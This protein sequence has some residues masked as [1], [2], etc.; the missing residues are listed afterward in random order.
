MY[1]KLTLLI[2]VVL[3][4]GLL[5]SCTPA[6]PETVVETR[7]VVV[8]EEREVTRTI[9]E[10]I[11]VTRVVVEEGE[12]AEPAPAAE[13]SYERSETLYTSG[14]Q[15]GP[16]TNWNPM[17]TWNYATGTI[18]LL[19]EPL[20][21]Y[22][23]L[24]DE[25]IPWLAESGEW[26]DDNVYEL[27]LREGIEWTDGEPFNAEDVVFTFELGQRFPTV[28]YSPMWDWLESAEQTDDYTVVFTFSDPLYQ[29][30]GNFLYSRVMVPEHLWA[31]KTEEEV[32][33]GANENPV[34]TGPYLYE[35]H[36]QDRMVWVKND[37]WWAIDALDM[38]VA[39]RRIVDIVNGSNNVAL[40]MVL[41]GQLD[42][43]NNFLPGVAT[44]VQGGYGV[45]TYYP[46][47]PYM[48]SANTAWLVMN[49][50]QTPTDDPA[51][52]RAMAH[53]INVDEIVEVVYGNIVQASN[54]TGLLPI[55]DEY[56]DQAV[57]DEM[58]FSYDPDQARAILA[59]A[60]YEDTDGDGFVE[61]PDGEPIELTIIVPFGW[62]DWMEAARVIASSAQAAGINVEPEFPDFGGYSDQR[63][64]GNYDLLVSNDAQ[65]S[66]TV[67]TYYDWIFQEPVQETMTNGNYQRYDNQE[68]FDLVVELD[69]TPVDDTEAM[70]E[71][72]S[73]LQEIQL[74][75]MPIVP[76][77]YN[78]LWAQYNNTYWTNWPSAEEG[79]N[80]YL[81]ATWR[82]YWNMTGILMLTEIEP[83]EAATE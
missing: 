32:V 83:A 63:N 50:E 37:N 38:D 27:T 70:Q 33:S 45:Q 31:D 59:E 79:S 67:W 78:G 13:T 51:F 44:L 19:Y 71:I 69:K 18:G 17:V 14:T 47:P 15:W 8:T 23:P 35:T 60:G 5:A 30:W 22:D 10:E 24:A 80:Q 55:W 53:A 21:L 75:D 76:L 73:Q 1:K 7:E 68:V 16:P 74:T 9:T 40:G 46:E 29:E 2:A 65:M 41:Q 28:Q 25:Y 77:W 81:P 82:G 72:I 62:T 12:E 57:V 20:F 26:T 66:N 52:R 6:A 54:P 56:V 39:P 4:L 48:L 61:T 43:S 36:D 58:G 11:E 34:G 49:N 42:L 64:S 3:A